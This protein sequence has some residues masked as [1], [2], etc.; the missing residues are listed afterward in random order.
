MLVLIFMP[1][2]LKSKGRRNGG[3]EGRG[4]KGEKEGEGLLS[5]FLY[6]FV[7]VRHT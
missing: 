2:F 6:V 3:W 5:S 4:T 1:Y 7:F